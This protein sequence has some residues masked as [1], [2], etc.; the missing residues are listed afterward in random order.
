LS[1][2]IGREKAVSLS[3]AIFI[4]FL[5]LLYAAGVVKSPPLVYAAAVLY[6]I[7]GAMPLPALMAATGDIFQGRH[8]GAIIGVIML[9]GFVGG[10]FGAWLGGQLF[11]LT[12]S[13]DAHFTLTVLVTLA[14]AALIW[15]AR[16]SQVRAVRI[17]PAG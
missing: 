7:G 12:H 15:R 10:A 2:R 17:A 9:G 4:L 3:A 5:A 6:G 13:Y 8:L 14:S 16:P 11:D 1:D